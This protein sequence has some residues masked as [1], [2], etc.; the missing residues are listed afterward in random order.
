LKYQS[1]RGYLAIENWFAGY[2]Q[3]AAVAR[4]GGFRRLVTGP[5]SLTGAAPSPP[6][7]LNPSIELE[8]P[9]V[10]PTPLPELSPPRALPPEP[11]PES[12]TL[13][14]PEPTTVLE[15]PPPIIRFLVPVAEK[16]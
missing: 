10:P 7:A 4:A 5:T 14:P 9:T 3:G 11:A 13:L 8:Q 12:A 16:D 2:R 1:P 6:V 15:Q